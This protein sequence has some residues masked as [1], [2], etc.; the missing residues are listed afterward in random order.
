MKVSRSVCAAGFILTAG[1]IAWGVLSDARETRLQELLTS[2][3]GAENEV[4][5]LGT[6]LMGGPD[7]VRLRIL[8]KDGQRRVDFLGFERPSKAARP[9]GPRRPLAGGLPLVLRPGRDQWMRKIK[10]ASL[11]VRNYD[12]SV[13]GSETRT[14]RRLRRFKKAPSRE[15][16]RREE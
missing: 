14:R 8:S 5:Y 15:P 4:P 7:P 10:D 12:I 9:A 2:I 16:G 3:E 13:T 11:A 1:A 6:R